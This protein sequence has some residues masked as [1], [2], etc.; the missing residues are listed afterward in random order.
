[1][2]TFNIIVRICTHI[3]TRHP[4]F[5]KSIRIKSH[6]ITILLLNCY[7]Q[8]SGPPKDVD[9]GVNYFVRKFLQKNKD[10]EKIFWHVTCAT[11]TKSIEVVF[12]ACKEIVITNAL[13]DQGF[14]S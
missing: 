11:D 1:M 3:L 2:I 13:K 5:E 6:S 4:V 14:V 8:S 10:H 7:A 12:G 9:A